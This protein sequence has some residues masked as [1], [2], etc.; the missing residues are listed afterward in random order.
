MVQVVRMCSVP[1]SGSYMRFTYLAHRKRAP[2]LPRRLL[3]ARWRWFQARPRP[4]SSRREP[5]WRAEPWLMVDEAPSPAAPA[6]IIQDHL[7]SPRRDPYSGGPLTRA[8]GCRGRRWRARATQTFFVPVSEVVVWVRP[9]PPSMCHPS[10][11]FGNGTRAA[12]ND[13]YSLLVCRTLRSKCPPSR[14]ARGR[15]RSVTASSEQQ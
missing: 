6:A 13:S 7:C 11:V 4:P 15:P 12:Q 10:V 14:I 3:R 5:V 8:S 2:Y 9:Y 1:R